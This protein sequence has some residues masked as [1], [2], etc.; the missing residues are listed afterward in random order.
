MWEIA[1][2]RPEIH[3]R[4]QRSR[5]VAVG[6]AVQ[7]T[8]VLARY[9][10]S[11]DESPSWQS[12]GGKY[13]PSGVRWHIHNNG[14]DPVELPPA[15]PGSV[16]NDLSN[17]GLSRAYRTGIAAAQTN[18]SPYLLFVDQD[19]SFP[20]DF[21]ELLGRAVLERPDVALW[22][23]TVHGTRFLMSPCGMQR[24]R[25]VPLRTCDLPATITG[26][27]LGFINSGALY[28]LDALVECWDP[29]IDKLFLDNVDH[30]IGHFLWRAGRKAAWYPADVRQRFSD[31]SPS[32]RMDPRRFRTWRRDSMKYGQIT[33]TS[34]WQVYWTARRTARLLLKTGDLRLLR[35]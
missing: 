21:W 32:E 4:A 11:L 5:N 7:I 34:A 13:V 9:R 18:N 8:V 16:A 31:D 25:G 2:D 1:R 29:A 10:M 15:C 27:R 17:G 28:Q 14:P 26:P 20:P 22:L 6:T 24:G 3:E 23:P 30:A 33:G 35:P 12:L 19:T